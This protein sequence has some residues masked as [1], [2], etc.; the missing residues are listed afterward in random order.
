MAM[1]LASTSH[2]HRGYLFIIYLFM[3]A[4]N[5]SAF[6]LPVTKSYPCFCPEELFH[7]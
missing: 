6:S 1:G 7:L 5:S 3:F 2:S 4:R